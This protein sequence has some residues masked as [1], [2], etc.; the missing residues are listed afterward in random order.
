[1]V[2]RDIDYRI[3]A[4]EDRLRG[5]PWDIIAGLHDVDKVAAQRRVQEAIEVIA[6]TL[7]LPIATLAE[8]EEA[9][10]LWLRRVES[11]RAVVNRFR[12]AGA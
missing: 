2:R 5:K 7:K 1:M 4:L 10:K 6:R 12:R 8:A 3:T 9:P 11:H